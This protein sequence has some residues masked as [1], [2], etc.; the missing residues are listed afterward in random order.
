MSQVANSTA[1]LLPMRQ[2]N[3]YGSVAGYTY[4]YDADGTRSQRIARV[5]RPSGTVHYYFSNHLGSHTMVTSATGSCEQDI[6]YFPYGGEITDHCPNVAQHYKFTGKERDTESGLDNFGARYNASSLG[7]F[8]TPDPLQ[9]SRSHPLLLQQF[10]A[11]PQNWNKY[12]YGLNNP[13]KDTDQGGHFTGDDHER[14]QTNAM[15]ANGYSPAA[16]HIAATADR[17]MDNAPN[18]ASGVPILHH[19]TS[20]AY[21]NQA[22][23]QHG[24]T[25]DHK[26]ASRQR[27]WRMRSCPPRLMTPRR[28]PFRETCA[29][30]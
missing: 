24:E 28:E 26:P 23:P 2:Q 27:A 13:V 20:D 16:V 3:R 18:M 29:V 15:L 21:Q 6:D 5:D 30:P 19:F 12:A 10:L 7:R 8:M 14:I 4:S 25:G 9:P 17:H 22:N 1:T 11:D